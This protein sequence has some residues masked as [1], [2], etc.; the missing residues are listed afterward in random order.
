[1]VR[2]LMRFLLTQNR[3]WTFSLQAFLLLRKTPFRLVHRYRWQFRF[4][5]LLSRQSR[6]KEF[7][8]NIKT[9]EAAFSKA[10]CFT[11]SD[12]L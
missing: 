12:I 3:G 6:M 7:P 4:L 1:M 9:K 2:E 5:F 10:Y 8:L 11:E